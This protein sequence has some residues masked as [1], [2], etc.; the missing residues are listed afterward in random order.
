M[1]GL[2]EGAD[3][4]A[5]GGD[6]GEA[7]RSS[8]KHGAVDQASGSARRILP[9]LH[10]V[11]DSG[12]GVHS[13]D[14]HRGPGQ[15]AV[16]VPD[17]FRRKISLVPEL[18]TGVPRPNEER[19]HGP[20]QSS[21][22]GH[23]G[24]VDVAVLD[25]RGPPPPPGVGHR[26]IQ[27]RHL[28]PRRL[29][30]RPRRNLEGDIRG[31]RLQHESKRQSDHTPRTGNP[32]ANPQYCNQSHYPPAVAICRPPS[33]EPRVPSAERRAPSLTAS[34]DRP[35]PPSADPPPATLPSATS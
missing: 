25:G 20:A 24:M 14:D 23:P 30:K 33:P 35:P 9:S 3:V 27:L 6:V 19:H 32:N 16:N 28:P 2:A 34:P 1:V 17:P 12:Q 13:E 8:Q 18:E 10:Q 22:D 31:R 5:G 29:Q 21:V 7:G 26:L 15:G 4:V 11:P